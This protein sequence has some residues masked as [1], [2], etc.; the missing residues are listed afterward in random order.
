[1]DI[2]PCWSIFQKG[3]SSQSLVSYSFTACT[4]NK[5]NGIFSFQRYGKVIAV[6]GMNPKKKYLV[7]PEERAELLRGMLQGNPD[8]AGVSVEGRCWHQKHAMS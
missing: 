6:V 5:Y 4:N 1:M 7:S 2:L 3:E 8:T